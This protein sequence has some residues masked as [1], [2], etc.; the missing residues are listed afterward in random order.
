MTG[1][2]GDADG[3]AL[4]DAEE[5]TR[6]VKAGRLD[7]TLQ[8]LH[9]AR[10]RK[11]PHLPVGHAASPHLLFAVATTAYILVAIRLEERDLVHEHGRPY[12]EYR[13]RVPMLWPFARRSAPSSRLTRPAANEASC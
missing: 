13:R 5:R 12:E 3:R 2:I 4:G 11:V 9:P 7:H 1:G 6:F 10:E 8:V